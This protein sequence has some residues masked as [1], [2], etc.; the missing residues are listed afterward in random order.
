MISTV[1]NLM[2]IG[3]F[4]MT[5]AVVVMSYKEAKEYEQLDDTEEKLLELMSIVTAR[6]Y[7]FE[8]RLN[9]LEEKTNADDDNR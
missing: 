1:I 4:A 3:I 6:Q 7:E 8:R 2:L 9:R 5:V